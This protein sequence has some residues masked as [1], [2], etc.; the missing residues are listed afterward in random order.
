MRERRARERRAVPA[1]R[2]GASCLATA[3]V[4]LAAASVVRATAAG[5]GVDAAP[6]ALPDVVFADGT[7]LPAGSGDAVRGAAAYLELCAD[8]HGEHGEGGSAPELVGDPASLDTE[9]PDRGVAA[10]WPYAPPLFDYVRRAMPPDAPGTLD[11]STAYAILARVF[12]LD[13]LVAPGATVD[14]AALAALRMPVRDRFVDED[15]R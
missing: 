8:C 6:Y 10:R 11:A 2:A 13:G 14:A 1:H 12:E 5:E 7:G 4:M 3:V 15:V 9:Y